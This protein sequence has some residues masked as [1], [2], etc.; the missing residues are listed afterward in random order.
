MITKKELY[1]AFYKSDEY[2]E[3]IEKKTKGIS[4]TLIYGLVGGI[5]FIIIVIVLIAKM[6]R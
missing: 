5:V 2:K 4:D 6:R 1:N 3:L